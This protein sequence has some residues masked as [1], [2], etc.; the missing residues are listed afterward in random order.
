[1]KGSPPLR[2]L[3]IVLG[4]WAVL[5][6]AFIIPPWSTPPADTIAAAV[7][8]RARPALRRDRDP[9]PLL[10]GHVPVGDPIRPRATNRLPARPAPRSPR[11][12]PA[13]SLPTIA[14]GSTVTALLAAASPSLPPPVALPPGPAPASTRRWSLSAWTFVRR[15]DSAALAV[16]GLLGGSQAGTRLTYRLNRD[17]ARPLALSVRVSAPLRRAAG[18]EAALG[19]DWRPLG[20]LPVHLLAE[21]RQALGR[22]GRTAF[23]VTFY[24]GVGD[25][26][27]GPFRIDAYAQAGI[28]G[29]RSR[30]PFAD[31]SLRLS[32]PLGA[33][34]RVGAGAWA[35]AQP[36]LS[37]LDLGPQAALRLPVAGRPLTLAADWRVRVAGNARP[38]SGPTLT[39]AT[40]F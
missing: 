38:G 8:G 5:R 37:R 28:V 39:L 7:Q 26:P 40:D 36:G 35:A 1:M 9:R 17:R 6:T 25:A 19:L 4:G 13:A 27:L 30:D 18:A 22:D 29:A 33:V 3:A 15:G 14:P 32:L 23:G 31:G 12:A 34:A 16:G 21:R 20:R 11:Q 10:A 2:F 24:G